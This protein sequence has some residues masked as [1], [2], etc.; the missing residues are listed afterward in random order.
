MHNF[1]FFEIKGL[2]VYSDLSAVPCVRLLDGSGP[3]CCQCLFYF[4][5][6]FNFEN[7]QIIIFW[8]IA[9]S[10]T[11]GPL[12]IFDSQAELDDFIQNDIFTVRY[13]VVL[14]PQLFTK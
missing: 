7:K 3:F 14:P 9:S 11:S 5:L 10:R 12:I 2:D 1:F 4:F 13:A 6:S 8:K